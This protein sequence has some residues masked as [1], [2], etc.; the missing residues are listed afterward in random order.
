M[1]GLYASHNYYAEERKQY[2]EAYDLKISD[3]DV[4]LILRKLC[5]RFKV[6]IPRIRL[7][8][9]RDSGSMG[10]MMKLSHNPSMGLLLHEFGHYAKEKSP[11]CRFNMVNKGTDHH[12]THF[13]NS[14]LR[15]HTY[16]KTRV[17]WCDHL[18]K[19]KERR[20]EKC[21]EKR[22]KEVER[23]EAKVAKVIMPVTVG[24]KVARKL[25]DIQKIE[26]NL[27]RYNKR[28]QY[29]TRLYGTKIKK[30]NRSLTANRR[31]LKKFEDA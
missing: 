7:W 29:F 18:A 26:D 1:A 28:L 3:N 19:R 14:L 13:Q 22:K 25:K 5:R 2:K 11:L 8:G 30:A 20:E 27:I 9:N 15:V 21:K 4:D 10:Y 23:I 12:G 17:Y 16:S 6:R 24:D 31:A